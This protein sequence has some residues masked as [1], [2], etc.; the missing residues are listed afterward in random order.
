[1]IRWRGGS[2]PLAQASQL[3]AR[4]QQTGNFQEAVELYDAILAK[5]PGI[6]E[7]HNNRGVVLQRMSRQEEALAGFTQAVKLKPDYANAHFNRGFL[8]KQMKRD[9]EAL[10]SYDRAI[11]LNPR[12]TDALNN[13]GVLLQ[14]LRRYAEAADSY[15]KAIAAD[16][17]SAIAYNN[18]G[19]SLM[20]QGDM[21]EAER[22]FCRAWELKPDFPDPLFNLANLRQYQDANPPEVRQIHALVNQAGLSPENREQLLFA[23]G[24]IY[25]DCG[26]YEEAFGNYSQAN[27]LRNARVAY[28]AAAVAKMTDGLIE[29]FGADSPA[30]PFD[31]A[32]ESRAPVFIVGMPRSGTTLIAN[33]LSNHRGV[34]MAGELHAMDELVSRLPEWNGNGIPYPQA[35]RHVTPAAAGRVIAGYEARLR[36]DTGPDVP[37]VIDKNPLNFRHLGF[38]G[39]LFPR[40]SIIHCTRHP[41][42]TA[43]SN[44]FQ[45]FPLTLDYCFD[46]RNIGHFYLQYARLME[47]WR[48][49]PG[50]KF[51]EVRY[52]DM[53]AD[54]ER[55]A[56]RVLEF[57][58]LDWE[59]NCLKPH[60]NPCPVE[61]ASQW[62]VRQ[63]IY[64]HSVGR[65][66]HYERQLEPLKEMLSAGGVAC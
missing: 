25:D 26:R 53:V 62:Q 42:D 7:V 63:P 35:A 43:L 46:L 30:R 20:S 5:F 66:R 13:R 49:L 48:K 61:N 22:M 45:R 65:W 59:E 50:L 52:E 60:T 9:E 58:G 15:A 10:A 56:R 36:R 38:I 64:Q 55:T 2:L 6:A 14:H 40:A 47:H 37:L 41:L 18:R 27:Q 28:D 16:P 1:M 4:Q 32:S 44:Y 51:V 11:A 8:L 54:T 39:R 31:G 29:A 21:K 23:L 24:K 12:H 33:I 57:A 19:T 17:H 3:A 34:G